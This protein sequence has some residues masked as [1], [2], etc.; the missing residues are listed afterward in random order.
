MFGVGW[1]EGRSDGIGESDD[2]LDEG[3]L[4]CVGGGESGVLEGELEE[5][6]LVGDAGEAYQ[7]LRIVAGTALVGLV[8][9]AEAVMGAGEALSVHLTVVILEEEEAGLA[10]EAVGVQ[11]AGEAAAGAGQT[12]VLDEIE[13]C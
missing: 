2:L 10:G 12:R 4:F 3:I 5:D 8:H 6:V 1:P 7:L 13:T 9:A 11:L